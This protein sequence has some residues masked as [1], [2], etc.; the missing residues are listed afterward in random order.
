MK[1]TLSAGDRNTLALAFFFA[2][3]DNE[4]NLKNSIIVLDDPISSLDDGRTITTVQKIRNL[5]PSCKQIIVLCHLRNFL[6]DIWEH[7]DK[8]NTVALKFSRAP[9]NTSNIVLWDVTSDALTEY[10]KRHKI[11][12]DYVE[13]DTQNKREVAQC[14]RPVM[15]KY[16]RI[17]FPGYCPPGTLLGNFKN[18]AENLWEKGQPIMSEVSFRELRDITEYANKFHHDTNPAW[19]TEQIIDNELVGFVKRVLNFVKHGTI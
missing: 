2:S 5:I 8:D 13:E 3:L 6:C 12:R 14:L 10:D 18:H 19:E 4:P 9:N 1:N 17:T 11:L 15:E 16:L 7:S